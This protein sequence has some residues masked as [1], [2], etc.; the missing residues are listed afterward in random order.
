MQIAAPDGAGGLDLLV[1][2]RVGAYRGEGRDHTT[3]DDPLQEA[4]RRLGVLLFRQLSE[5]CGIR[6]RWGILS[7]V[8]P[9]KLLRSLTGRFGEQEAAR[10]FREDYL[11]SE[12]KLRLSLVTMRNEGALLALGKFY[13]DKVDRLLQPVPQL[14]CAAPAGG[15]GPQG[16]EPFL[17]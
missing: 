10:I 8:R 17:I 1:R 13:R 3:A 7:G 15:Q 9:V 11:V 12:E 5:A 16:D 14:P 4:E 2:T 6:P